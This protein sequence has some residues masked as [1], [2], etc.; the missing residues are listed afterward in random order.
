MADKS[1][2][3]PSPA[4]RGIFS[5]LSHPVFRRIWFASLTSNLGLMVMGVGAAWAM[6]EM[7]NSPE[8]VAL[9]Q[10]SLMLPIALV[11]APAGAAAD[12]FDRRIVSLI[13]L[14]ISFTGACSMTLLSWFG[15]LSPTTLLAFGFLIGCG[16][17]LMGPS[18]QASVSEQVPARDLPAAVALYGISWNLARS[19]GPAI[20]GVVVAAAGSVASFATN[21]LFYLPLLG[22]LFLWRRVSEPSRLPREGLKRAVISG[23]RYVANS[24]PI[25][26][27]L[28]RTLVTGFAGGSV[29]ALMPLVA[30]DLLHGNA[31][32]YGIMLGAFGVGAVIGALNI[33]KVRKYLSGEGAIRLCTLVMGGAIMVVAVSRL[34]VLTAAALVIAGGTVQ[35]VTARPAPGMMRAARSPHISPE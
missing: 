6:T 12:M 33:N 2:A 7:T 27:V 1:E 34:P 16:M 17:A 29:A 35:L 10:A 11:S 30:R 4:R 15:A 18:W 26:V 31:Q 14:T 9:V 28:T 19:F 22:A 3:S 23:V 8:M 32:T 13:A 25:R 21:A 24:P 20:G 5:P